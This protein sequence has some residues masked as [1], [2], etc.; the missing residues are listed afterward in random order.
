MQLRDGSI[1]ISIRVDPLL[2]TIIASPV[3]HS[4]A[5]RMTPQA[6]AGQ[7]SALFLEHMDDAYTS[8]LDGADNEAS[9]RQLHSPTTGN[10]A[11]QP[12]TISSLSRPDY[13]SSNDQSIEPSLE[14][15]DLA[16]ANG[17]HPILDGTTAAQ[18]EQQQQEQRDQQHFA[19][20]LFTE[21]PATA[22]WHTPTLTFAS[23]EAQHLPQTSPNDTVH[24]ALQSTSQK[25]TL[26]SRDVTEETIED[27]YVLFILYC[28]P[29][30]PIP[31]DSMD[32]KRGFRNP[33]RS[34]GKSFSTYALFELVRKLDDKEIKSWSQLVLK[35]G[36]E[37]PIAEKNQSA[38]KVQQYAV[39]LKVGG[40]AIPCSGLCPR[41]ISL[42]LR[43]RQC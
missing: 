14:G 8:T 29:T 27:A 18:L 33:P 21:S 10:P 37:P 5:S 31:D 22:H 34:D 11:S 36:V 39:R 41:I 38:Q 19:G 9:T 25:R 30:I 2:N 40:P 20:R 7:G 12:S 24:D 42:T 17:A 6:S 28:N 15:E 16:E 43:A 3:A 13:R 23:T 26:P 4:I 32:L 1:A 35:L